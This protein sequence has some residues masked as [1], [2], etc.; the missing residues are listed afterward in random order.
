MLH[1]IYLFIILLLYHGLRIV[2]SYLVTITTCLSVSYLSNNREFFLCISRL[3]Q[4]LFSCNVSSVALL[5]RF[6]TGPFL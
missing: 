5:N 1:Y 6:S 4:Q 3:Q 2:C